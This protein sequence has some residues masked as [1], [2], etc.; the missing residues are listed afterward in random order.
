MSVSLVTHPRLPALP[1]SADG[2]L[3]RQ[4]LLFGVLRDLRA[5]H[6]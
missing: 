3:N 5:V 4:R 2:A 1:S 6:E